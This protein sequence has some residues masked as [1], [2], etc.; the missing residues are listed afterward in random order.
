MIFIFFAVLL[1]TGTMYNQNECP[2]LKNIY[3]Y[4]EL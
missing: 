3:I 4:I 2:H 1:S